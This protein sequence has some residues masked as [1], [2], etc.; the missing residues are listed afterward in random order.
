VGFENR[1]PGGNAE[2]KRDY[3]IIEIFFRKSQDPNQS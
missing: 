1:L 2:K 3:K